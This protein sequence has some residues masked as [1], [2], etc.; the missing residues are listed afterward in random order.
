MTDS[1]PLPS[2]I[3]ANKEI[4]N[5]IRF[6]SIPFLALVGGASCVSSAQGMPSLVPKPTA[7]F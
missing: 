4:S 3:E 2:G 5:M 6:I 1:G 7:A